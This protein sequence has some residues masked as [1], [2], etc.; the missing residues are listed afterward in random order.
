MHSHHI[1]IRFN[2][3]WY[4]VRTVF[5]GRRLTTFEKALPQKIVP[6]RPV[7]ILESAFFL[8]EDVKATLRGRTGTQARLDSCADRQSMVFA[9][10]IRGVVEFQ[11]RYHS[12]GFRFDICRE[13]SFVQ[14]GK[15]PEYRFPLSQPVTVEIRIFCLEFRLQLLALDCLTKHRL[16]LSFMPWGA[17]A[18]VGVM[19]VAAARLDRSVLH[20]YPYPHDR[21]KDRLPS[22][23][24]QEI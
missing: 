2:Q 7:E 4:A 20:R 23:L 1:S 10:R 13:L 24:L 15:G 16:R 18:L 3:P 22:R 8:S 21:S 17:T 14:D 19:I 5:P 12:I 11:C 9:H 6:Y